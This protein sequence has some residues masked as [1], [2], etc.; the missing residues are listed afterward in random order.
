MPRSSPT[1]PVIA[2]HR[3]RVDVLEDARSHARVDDAGHGRGHLVERAERGEQ[4]GGVGRAGLELQR[5]LG[6]QREGPLRAHEQL[7]EV[8]AGRGL[9]ELAAG[10]DHLARG[11]HRLEAE[12]VMAGHAV[13]DGPHPAGVGGDVA[14]ERR[15]STPPGTP[16]RRGR[17]ARS[18]ASSCSRVT[19]GSTTATW[20]AVSISRIVSIRS[21][22]TKIGVRGSGW[23]PPTGRSRCRGPRRGPDRSSQMRRTA[24]TSVAPPGPDD[25]QRGARR[26][27][28][29]ASS[30]V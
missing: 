8:V 27:P 10:A 6:D 4:G 20:L 24:A 12:D 29:S 15:R 2:A 18:A 26:A 21:K 3:Q 9:D 19:P 30:W 25:G 22:D 7:G 11:E 23:P 28:V 17:A 13:L 14:A 5:G 16:G 1:L